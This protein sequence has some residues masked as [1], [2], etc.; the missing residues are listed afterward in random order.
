[1]SSSDAET[2]VAPDIDIPKPKTKK[3]PRKRNLQAKVVEEK[4]ADKLG[5]ELRDE[6]TSIVHHGSSADFLDKLALRPRYSC[7]NMNTFIS[8]SGAPTVISTTTAT[9]SGRTTS[10]ESRRSENKPRPMKAKYKKCGNIY[11]LDDLSAS[12]LA[13]NRPID[14]QYRL[15]GNVYT[16][17]DFK[18]I[19]ALEALVD[20]HGKVSHMGILD[21]SYSFFITE[22]RDAALYFKVKDK[23]AVVGGDPLCNRDAIDGLLMEF[24]QY[25]KTWGWG[26]A[27]LGATSQ[28]AGYAQN[29]NWVTMKFGVERVLNP[30]TNPVLLETGS[31]KR[32]IS[33]SKQLLRNGITLG[34]Y[35]PKHQPD[36]VLQ[37]QLVDIYE[38]WC[39]N[40]NGNHTVQAYLTVYDPFAI[41]DL[42]TYIYTK[43]ASGVPNGFAALRKIV[44]GY[45]IDPC[46]A[47]PGAARGISELLIISTMS[48][49]REAGVSYL[50]LGF[51]PSTELGE[52]SG[53]A[54]PLQSLTR[55]I[56]RRT[57][58]DLPIGGKRD[59]H[60]KFRPDEEQEA[61]LYLV[62]PGRMPQLKHMKA[63]MHVV[64][65]DIS[66]LIAEDLRKAMLTNVD[67]SKLN[68]EDIKK[69]IHWRT[70]KND[71]I[72]VEEKST[73]EKL[74][75]VKPAEDMPVEKPTTSRRL[76]K[77]F[78]MPAMFAS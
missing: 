66:K 68:V 46:I 38:R 29:R 5:R 25:R 55:A 70:E 60:D 7:D 18:A 28:F 41:P 8:T 61:D 77:A 72:V 4:L 59:F 33:Q 10:T 65:I 22:K 57:Y 44:N 23:V 6:L 76:K 32:S 73:V 56:H 3:Q 15:P 69:A 63:T 43:D 54:K 34:I 21:R 51:E 64:N 67:F 11:T 36:R 47:M 39:S 75:E 71:H 14:P 17:A 50:S 58:R 27:F 1:M 42:M 19:T 9:E 37:A 26:I 16:L 2:L 62:F 49:L 30:M 53:L 40:R 31:G 52:I 35:S 78:S 48:L 74:A 20:E 12:K 45:H 24:R 13:E